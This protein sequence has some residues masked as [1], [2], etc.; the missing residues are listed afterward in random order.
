MLAD[1]DIKERMLHYHVA[2]LRIP[3]GEGG[4]DVR[5]EENDC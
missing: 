2:G 4:Y 5:N 1:I 3:Q